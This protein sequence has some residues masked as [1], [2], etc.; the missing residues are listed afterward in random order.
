MRTQV[1]IV[2]AGAAGL[3]AARALTDRGL[4]VLV[5]EARDRVGGRAYTLPTAGGAYPVEL[6]A[7][8][9]H[10]P[11]PQTMALLREAGESTL[12]IAETPGDVWEAAERVLQRVDMRAPDTS[13]DAFL[14]SVHDPGV[15]QARML[16]EGFDAA[17]T[18]DASIH[19][20]A[21]EWS[22]QGNDTQFRP[23]RGYGVLMQFLATKIGRRVL[24]DSP[25][26]EIAW[27]T[28]AVT[29]RG[30]RSGEPFEVHARC[31][32]VTLPIGVLHDG[33]VRFVPALPKDT[34]TA[35]D[36]IGA[37]PVIKVMLE[38]ASVFWRDGFLQT[39][40][41]CPFPT[42]WSRM[43]QPAPV[44]AAWAGGD[45]VL[46]LTEHSSDPVDEAIRACCRLFPD[47]DVRGELQ[48]VHWHDWQSD[49]YARGA[50]SYLRVNGGDARARLGRPVHDVLFFAGE[51]SAAQD[52]GTVAGAFRTG[53]TA[54][55]QVAALLG[56]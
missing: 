28:D 26:R 11:A 51:A 17:I 50:Y 18:A 15:D 20:I 29:V 3:A 4:D 34:A 32:I 10:G 8:F 40:P 19:A 44:L 48:A 7:E 41:E 23:A 31:A 6:G 39:Q 36:A 42:V 35:I 1:V 55:A 25:V 5:V 13:V 21:S 52:S 56:R 54:A 46:R 27:S 47:V 33:A 37:G 24:L 45:A 53:H 38:F 12:H 9:I 2:G 30:V 14:K 49:P 22:G 43:P 16:I